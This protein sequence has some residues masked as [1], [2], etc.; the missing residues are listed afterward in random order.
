MVYKSFL[1]KTII[2]MAEILLNKTTSKHN[3]SIFFSKVRRKRLGEAFRLLFNVNAVVFVQ[4][5]MQVSKQI[6]ET[7]N[8]AS[9]LK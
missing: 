3:Y 2:L 5:L 6:F 1:V 8:V 9:Y 4:K 7:H